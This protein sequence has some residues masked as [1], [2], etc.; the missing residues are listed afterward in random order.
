VE[1]HSIA[2][3]GHPVLRNG[4]EEQPQSAHHAQRP[5]SMATTMRYLEA[6]PARQADAM[7]AYGSA[8]RWQPVEGGDVGHVKE[9]GAEGTLPPASSAGSQRDAK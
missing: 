8:I 9:V 2:C 3:D 6:D 7:T 1:G 4:L 5:E